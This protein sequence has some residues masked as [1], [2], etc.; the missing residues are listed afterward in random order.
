[1][2]YQSYGFPI[3]LTE[4]M[5]KEKKIKIDRE[6]FDKESGKH[7]KLSKTSAKGKFSSGL[8]DNSEQTTKLHTATHLLNEALRK[9]IDKNIKQKGSN[10]TP[11]RLRFDFNFN[12][13]LTDKEI[14]KVEDFVNK[15]ISEKI[16]VTSEEIPLKKATKIAQAEFGARYPDT[17][18]VYSI[19]NFSKE[20]C[21]GPHVK[22]TRDIGKFKIIKEESSAAGVRRIRAVVE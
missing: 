22:N 21:T 5:A 6:S 19:G 17:V 1:M 20:I 11:E 9:I 7:Q 4:E 13:K 2:L 16:K 15:K 8:A 10:I 12:R 3:E 14:K 18:S